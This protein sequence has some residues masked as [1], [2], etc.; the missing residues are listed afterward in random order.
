MRLGLVQVDCAEV[1][2]TAYE[3]VVDRVCFEPDRS[4]INDRKAAKGVTSR[5]LVTLG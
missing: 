4:E 3:I 2:R 1:G 5:A